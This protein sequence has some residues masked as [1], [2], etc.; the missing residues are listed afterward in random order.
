MRR[1][2]LDC[3]W[4]A[5][6]CRPG[7]LAAFA[8]QYLL[9]VRSVASRSFRGTFSRGNRPAAQARCEREAARS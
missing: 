9:G 1:L 3:S 6:V 8:E 4:Q 5:A 7:S 2:T